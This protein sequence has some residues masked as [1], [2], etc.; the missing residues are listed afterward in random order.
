[1]FSGNQRYRSAPGLLRRQVILL[2]G[3]LS[4]GTFLDT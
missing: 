1:M 4:L 3:A 2:G